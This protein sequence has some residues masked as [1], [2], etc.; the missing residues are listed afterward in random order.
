MYIASGLGLFGASTSKPEEK[1]DGATAPGMSFFRVTVL[2]NYNHSATSTSAFSLSTKPAE[3]SAATAS[4]MSLPFA[5][6]PLYS[7]MLSFE[8]FDGSG[9]CTTTVHATWKDH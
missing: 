9:L 5:F 2:L 4:S 8:T 1:K 7:H 6:T 3:S